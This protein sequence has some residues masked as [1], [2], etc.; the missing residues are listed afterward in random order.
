MS[1]T[2]EKPINKEAKKRK[3]ED[4]EADEES[5]AVKTNAD[6]EPYFE[7]SNMRRL[8]IRKFKGKILVDI[9]EVRLYTLNNSFL[10]SPHKL[11]CSTM[12]TRTPQSQVKKE[13]L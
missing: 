5:S 6:G 12:E 2:M 3:V 1:E 10:Y 4:D 8:S 7:L 13:Y 11:L 9:R